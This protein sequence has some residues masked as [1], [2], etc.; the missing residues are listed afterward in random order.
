MFKVTITWK[1][2]PPWPGEDVLSTVDFMR[3][4]GAT[5]ENLAFG[6]QLIL[7][8]SPLFVNFLKATS[9]YDIANKVSWITEIFLETQE[10]AN[11][12][13]QYFTTRATDEAIAL[14]W[15]VDVVL[16]IIE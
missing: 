12:V 11:I 5:E 3:L 16:E 9:E 10:Q 1:D 13:H 15:T 8:Q 2:G 4:N 6:T 14:N 7:S